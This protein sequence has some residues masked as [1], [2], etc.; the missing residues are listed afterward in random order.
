MID[1]VP[2]P[3][4]KINSNY[5]YHIYIDLV[6]IILNSSSLNFAIKLIIL[7]FIQIS[8]LYKCYGILK[9]SLLPYFQ[10]VFFHFIQINQAVQIISCYKSQHN[11]RAKSCT[12]RIGI[13][14]CS[15]QTQYKV[16]CQELLLIFWYQALR[17]FQMNSVKKDICKYVYLIY[18]LK[19]YQ[20][21]KTRKKNALPLF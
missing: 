12:N 8:L 11:I 13:T 20:K 14:S 7:Y 2:L 6:A 18:H 15:S 4:R 9:A 3:H 17:H 5:D 10:K 1:W 16:K 19:Q 21:L